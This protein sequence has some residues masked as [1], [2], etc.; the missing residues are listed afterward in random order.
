MDAGRP[1]A[2]AAA[3]GT[4][5]GVILLAV[6]FAV[7]DGARWF[8]AHGALVG[9]GAVLP[10]LLALHAHTIERFGRGMAAVHAR[11]GAALLLAVAGVNAAAAL[12]QDAT[13]LPVVAAGL[14]VVVAVGLAAALRKGA[15]QGSVVDIAADPLTKGDDASWLHLRIAPWLLAAAA[16][17]LFAASVPAAPEALVRLRLAGVHVLFAGY[18]LLSVYGLGHIWVPRLSG[19]PAI[20]AG[21]IKGELHATLLG[22]AGLVVGLAI[23][24]TALVVGFGPFVF[25]GFF[26]YMG[27]LGANIMR[28]K[29][30][31]QR[32]T[33]EFVYV[34]WTFAAIFWLVSGVLLGLFLN[35]V[36][37]SLEPQAAALRWTHVHATL[38]AGVLMLLMGFATRIVPA[39]TGRPP[40][41]FQGAL[42]ASFLFTN[43]AIIAAII[44]RFDADGTG[45]PFV[46]ANAGIAFGLALY[47]LAMK[48]FIRRGASRVV[49]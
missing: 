18:G 43:L 29:S 9:Y 20:A 41:R 48:A 28:N 42:R 45:A 8:A 3:L 10:G 46:A 4:T 26:T 37:A 14:F 21:A 25:L 19:V 38:F 23:G 6:G 2:L 12:V 7:D 31:T 40:M 39:V 32:V 34:P 11:R 1:L 15:P 36:P 44:T 16:V 5:V 22:L 47:A 30:V 17:V 27:V 33:P 49:G 24:S 35:V 13:V